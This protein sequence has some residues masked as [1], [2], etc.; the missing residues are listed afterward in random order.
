MHRQ[1]I[2]AG[3][4]DADWRERLDRIV[5]QFV[6]PRIDRMRDGDHQDGV[7]IGRR[8]GRKL[9][10]DDAAGAGAVVRRSLLACQRSPIVARWRGRT[11]SLLP[12]A[13]N[14]MIRRI[15]RLG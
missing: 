11:M 7:T 15:G 13:G 4:H 1:H 5:G 6:Q 3:A 14:G 10:A 8:M 2:G 9:G 12:P